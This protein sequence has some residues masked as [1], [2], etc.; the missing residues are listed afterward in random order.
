MATGGSTE[1][2]APAASGFSGAGIFVGAFGQEYLDQRDVTGLG[3]Q[4]QGRVAGAVGAVG[5][6]A[7]FEQ[8]GRGGCT[9]VR[10]SRQQDFGSVGQGGVDVR[11]RLGERLYRGRV[12]LDG[13]EEQGRETGLRGGLDVAAFF[14]Q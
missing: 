10:R 9:A 6:S 3:R 12:V 2:A 7:G 14:N 5:V 13:G 4:M 8:G 11:A 1:E